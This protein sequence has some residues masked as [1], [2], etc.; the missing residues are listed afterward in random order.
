M[1]NSFS[2]HEPMLASA[3]EGQTKKPNYSFDRVFAKRFFRLLKVLFSSNRPNKVWSTSKEARKYS[4]FWLYMTF[5]V[6]GVSY[7]AL[8]YFVG[9]TPS[10]FYT[11]LT[12]R[13]SV[14]FR[15]FIVPCLLLVFSTATCKSL[16]NFMGG[17]FAIKARRLL[18]THLQER[19]IKP[20]SMYTLVMNHEHIDNPDQRITQD[21]DKFSETL[22]EIVTKLII[23]PIMVVYYTYKCW[24][25]SGFAGPLFIFGYF[26]IG[27]FVSKIFIQPIVNAVFFKELQEGN[28]RYL[29]VRLRQY[30]ESIAFCDGEV[31]EKHRA[32]KSLDTLLTYQRNIVNKE[33]PLKLTNESFSYL[34]AILSYIIIAIPIF[35][36]I[37]DDKDASELSAIISANSFVAMYL[38][39]LFSTIIEES[40]KLSDLAGYTARIGE[41][42]EALDRVADD[43]KVMEIDHPHH[44][45]DDQ[46]NAIEFED[47]TLFSPRSKLIVSDLNLKISQGNHV[48]FVGPNGSGKTSVLRA[49]AGLWPCTEGTIRIPKVRLGKDLIFL[50][51]LP[52]LIDGSLREQIVYPNTTPAIKITDQDII[53]LLEKVRLSHLSGLIQSYDT[54]YSQE[55][56]KFLSP[57]EQQRLVFARILYWKPRFA[58]LDEATSSMD[59][60][61]EEYLYRTL[62][63]LG[64]TVISISHRSSITELHDTLVR[65]DGEGGYT[66]EEEN[67]VQS[68]LVAI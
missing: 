4:I 15:N 56:N 43:I 33:L 47:V 26:V 50:P 27:S 51:Q 22:R 60:E 14:G 53:Q 46:T 58:V 10:R 20:K 35:T 59:E 34:G 41:F 23:A 37:L 2:S 16:L 66:I 63:D 49:L 9:M 11:I 64:I 54:S 48:A 6:L 40:S 5:I 7:E 24:I 25:V 30:A 18:T 68:S 13:D 45:Q 52:Y 38:I 17:L 67:T 31:E 61:T 57:G 44:F 19:Y 42:L 32:G 65:L 1:R 8:A 3:E 55:W 36:G 28:F 39:Y 12:S 21:V 29:H 62:I